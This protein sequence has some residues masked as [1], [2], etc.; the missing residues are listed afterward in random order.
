MSTIKMANEAAQEVCK[1]LGV[2]HRNVRSITIK[3]EAWQIATA[4][5]EIV[6]TEEQWAQIGTVVKAADE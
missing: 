5:I 1:I 6:I 3:L 4:Q 2:E